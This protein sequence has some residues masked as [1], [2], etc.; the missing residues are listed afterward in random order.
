[1]PRRKTAPMAQKQRMPTSIP[2]EVRTRVMGIVERFN[3]QNLAAGECYYVARFRG[4]YCYLYRFDYGREGP[5][6]RLGYRGEPDD[7]EFAIFKW[8]TESY[9]R[10]ERM[11]PGSQ[12][13]D[14]TV[15]GAMRAGIEAYPA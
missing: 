7:W 1:M 11:F 10:D 4:R 15:R 5:I 6:C 8:S 3:R 2:D 9:D 13:V 12:F 14:G